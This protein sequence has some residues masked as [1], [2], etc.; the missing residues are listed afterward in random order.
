MDFIFRVQVS[1]VLAL[2]DCITI[3]MTREKK[4]YVMKR[5]HLNIPKDQAE[6]HRKWC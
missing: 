1:G 2:L 6:S 5:E 4:N 3:T